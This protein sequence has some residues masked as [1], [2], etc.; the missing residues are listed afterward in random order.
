LPGHPSH[1]VGEHSPLIPEVLGPSEP[2]REVSSLVP[3]L[4][5]KQEPLGFLHTRQPL[6]LLRAP[7]LLLLVGEVNPRVKRRLLVTTSELGERP[8][9]DRP[10]TPHLDGDVAPLLE[11]GNQGALAHP[12]R[13]TPQ[14][15]L[16]P[17]ALHTHRPPPHERPEENFLR[18]GEQEPLRAT[19]LTLPRPRVASLFFLPHS[20]SGR[21]QLPVVK[22]VGYLAP[23]VPLQRAAHLGL[24]LDVLLR[25]VPPTVERDVKNPPAN[26]PDVPLRRPRP[27]LPVLSGVQ[28]VRPLVERVG[29]G[30]ARQLGEHAGHD[31][32]V[33]SALVR[34]GRP[35]LERRRRETSGE[36]TDGAREKPRHPLLILEPPPPRAPRE[37][38]PSLVPVELQSLA[39]V[40]HHALEARFSRLA[41]LLRGHRRSDV[42][43]LPGDKVRP[44]VEGSRQVSSQHSLRA[45]RHRP[46]HPQQGVVLGEPASERQPRQPR[47][48][49][50]NKLRDD[51]PVV[52]LLHRVLFHPVH[53]PPLNR[54]AHQAGDLHGVQGVL[55]YPRGVVPP[56]GEGFPQ[57]R[58]LGHRLA[59]LHEPL[60]HLDAEVHGV[61]VRGRRR[62]IHHGRS[63]HRGGQHARS[64]RRGGRHRPRATR[65]R[66]SGAR[67]PPPRLRSGG[68]RRRRGGRRGGRRPRPAPREGRQ[69]Q[70]RLGGRRR[71]GLEPHGVE[72]EVVLLRR[73]PSAL[74]EP[75]PQ[76]VGKH[77]L[78]GAHG[79][80]QHLELL[81]HAEVVRVE[82][83][84]LQALP[85][86]L[87]E[88]PRAR[89]EES[90]VPA[91]PPQRHH[92][93]LGVRVRRAREER[94]RGPVAELEVQGAVLALHDHESPIRRHLRERDER[95]RGR[96]AQRFRIVVRSRA[97][98][99]FEPSR[100][101]GEQR[102]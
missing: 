6:A 94:L 21:Q 98:R 70:Q 39:F 90:D 51:Q 19:N 63:H 45:A 71:R 10:L 77:L 4:H 96:Q 47:P 100:G 78:H 17:D 33:A 83:E 99:F 73:V 61:V 69:R 57:A 1:R 66:C 48:P 44:V 5:R 36:S 50:A 81:A 92:D 30:P 23:E 13:R 29:E 89:V 37:P 49:G 65:E 27:A 15:A 67:E 14:Q 12:G 62:V 102:R 88:P 64:V 53:V 55:L 60:Q 95:P 84:L 35:P 40:V 3:A 11:A 93:V 9:H 28:P 80:L 87:Q 43:H 59:L 101:V 18:H 54:A 41:L 8:R 72:P 76:R 68:G 86:G 52:S 58:L 75:R 16:Q 2:H 24:R 25:L 38:R 7:A 26:R 97:R 34:H 46:P 74:H 31:E 20:A 85:L 42:L 32:S 91:D 82:P 22:R 79:P 56:P